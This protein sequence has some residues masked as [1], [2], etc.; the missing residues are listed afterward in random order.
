MLW[1]RS[2]QPPHM[3]LRCRVKQAAGRRSDVNRNAFVAGLVTLLPRDLFQN[4]RFSNSKRQHEFHGGCEDRQQAEKNGRMQA[5]PMWCV[6]K[7]CLLRNF[8]RCEMKV[9]MGGAMRS[10]ST[11]LAA[12]VHERQPQLQSLEQW[13]DELDAGMLVAVRADRAEHYIEGVYWLG[14]CA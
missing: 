2:T 12:G 5:R 9:Q 3:H 8:D 1:F 10:V 13:G 14:E 6:C 4:K 7:W 11:P